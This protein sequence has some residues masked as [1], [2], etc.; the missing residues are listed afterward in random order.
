MSPSYCIYIYIYI[1]PL[2]ISLFHRILHRKL[3]QSLD[4]TEQAT[5]DKLLIKTLQSLSGILHLVNNKHP[6]ECESENGR[7]TTRI[8]TCVQ[9]HIYVIMNDL[10]VLSNAFFRYHWWSIFVKQL[11]FLDNSFL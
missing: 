8:C 7:L 10:I 5:Y 9:Q 11:L 4:S 3:Q 2:I 1:Y 6:P